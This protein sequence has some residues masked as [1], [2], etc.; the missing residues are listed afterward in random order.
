MNYTKEQLVDALVH[1][2]EYL[3]HDD[4]DPQD[5]TPEEYRKEMEELTIEQ[6]IEETDTGEDYTLD[7]F[8]ECHGQMKDKYHNHN[9][10]ILDKKYVKDYVS[11]N[12]LFAVLPCGKK[13]MVICN[14]DPMGLSSSFDIAMRRVE[15][16]QKTY[17]KSQKRTKTPVKRK[18][19]KIQNK[20]LLN[21]SGGKGSRGQGGQLNELD[22]IPTNPLLDALQ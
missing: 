21:P 16:L 6:L 5:P 2:W 15:K 10:T 22:T 11:P 14:G 19:K 1:E 12:G 4:Y 13:W 18:S 20:H 9:S 17:S 3:C 8:M 7:E